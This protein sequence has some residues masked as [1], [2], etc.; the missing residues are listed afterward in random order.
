MQSTYTDIEQINL[1]LFRNLNFLTRVCSS[2]L[3]KFLSQNSLDFIKESLVDSSSSK[4]LVEL[5]VGFGNQGSTL[6]S[7]RRKALPTRN[8]LLQG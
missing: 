1:S 5:I 8:N 6:E 2:F 7:D 3:R 4:Y